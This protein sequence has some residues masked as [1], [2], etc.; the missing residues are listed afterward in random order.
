MNVTENTKWAQNG[1]AVAGGHGQGNANNQLA[2]PYGLYVDEDQT[3][4]IADL[5]NHRIVKWKLGAI[6][7]QV[8]AGGNGEGNQIDQLKQP[9]DVIV[10]KQT[11]SLIISDWGNRRVMR[12]SRGNRASAEIILD[13]IGCYGLTMDNQR[14]LYVSDVD[15]HEVRRYRVGESGGGWQ[16]SR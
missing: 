4:Y 13:N 9:I 2:N 15:K 14:Y 11:D 1:V 6:S 7:G 8:V 10:D 3:F 5:G 12:W 16:W